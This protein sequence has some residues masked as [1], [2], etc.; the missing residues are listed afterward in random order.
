MIL[1]DLPKIWVKYTLIDKMIYARERVTQFTSDTI[2]GSVKEDRRTGEA[3]VSREVH[4]K[5]KK[6][7]SEG[8]LDISEHPYLTLIQTDA[9]NCF[10]L[11]FCWTNFSRFIVFS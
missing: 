11:S 10:I 2:L 9:C 4:Q 7:R 6:K 8:L 5:A 3:E 1:S